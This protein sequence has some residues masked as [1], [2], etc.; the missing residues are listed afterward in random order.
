[1]AFVRGTVEIAVKVGMLREDGCSCQN[2]ASSGTQSKSPSPA[3]CEQP[4]AGGFK[5]CCSLKF[6]ILLP[7]AWRSCSSLTTG[8]R[9]TW[10]QR[11]AQRACPNSSWCETDGQRW[12]LH[13]FLRVPL[14]V[15]F[16][17]YFIRLPKDGSPLGF[18]PGNASAC[19]GCLTCL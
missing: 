2:S 9:D 7:R 18:G 17:L 16:G 8:F 12:D 10:E 5:A 4:S 3:W 19:S 13:F 6:T 11:F 14:C 1:M 15:I